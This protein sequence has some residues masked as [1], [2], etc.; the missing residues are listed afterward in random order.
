MYLL[1]IHLD[2]RKNWPMLHTYL[3]MYIHKSQ[4]FVTYHDI[5]LDLNL[6]R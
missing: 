2:A 3:P 4:T 5:A 6:R 1:F